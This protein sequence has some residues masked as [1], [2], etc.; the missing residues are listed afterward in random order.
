MKNGANQGRLHKNMAWEQRGTHEY[1][2]RTRKQ[3]GRI[4][5]QY[6]GRGIL[7]EIAAREDAERQKIREQERTEQKAWEAVDAQVDSLDTLIT[8]LSHSTLV[9]AGFYQ[10]HRSE[11]RRRKEKDGTQITDVY[12]QS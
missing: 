4:I 1:Y 3:Q 9:N 2:Y 8:L 11:W 10:H 6:Y 7:A 5:R 12:P